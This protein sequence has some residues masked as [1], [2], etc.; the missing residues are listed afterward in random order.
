MLRACI[1]NILKSVNSYLTFKKYI[2]NLFYTGQTF[3]V[4]VDDV[5]ANITQFYAFEDVDALQIVD[6]IEG[7]HVDPM[8]KWKSI[9]KG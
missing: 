8:M 2:R 6:E 4:Y 3:I 9:W 1:T 7:R 5:L